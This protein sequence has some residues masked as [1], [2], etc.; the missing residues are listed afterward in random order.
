MAATPVAF[1]VSLIGLFVDTEKKHAVAGAV[2]SG[3]AGLFFFGLPALLRC[4]I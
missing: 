4:G 1:T 3:A 2:I